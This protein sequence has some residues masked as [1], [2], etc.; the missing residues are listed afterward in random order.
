M[1]KTGQTN[2]DEQ[3]RKKYNIPANA[4]KD[5]LLIAYT[6]DLTIGIWIGYPQ[7]KAGH[8]IDN[9]KKTIPR[10]IMKILMTKFAKNNMFYD[11]IDGI[12]KKHI[13]IANGKAYLSTDLGFD[14]YFI[15]G[16]EPLSYYNDRK[17]I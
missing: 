2:Y 15:S 13:I 8:Y 5:S 17:R 4:T 12:I 7:I 3:T 14:E 10:S 9:Y 1:A 16:T 6:K 11:E